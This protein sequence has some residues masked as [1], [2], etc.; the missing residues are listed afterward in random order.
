MRKPPILE[1]DPGRASVTRPSRR[2]WPGK[3]PDRCVVTFFA[4]VIRKLRP[5]ARLVGMMYS[6]IGKHPFYSIRHRGRSVGVLHPGVGAAFGAA[7]LESAISRGCRKFIACGCSG[8][9]DPELGRGEIVVPV[10]AV[11]DEG[12]SYHYLRPSREVAASPRA[13]RAIERTLK[14]HGVPYRRGKTWTTDGFYRETAGK[15]RRRRREGCLVVEMEAAA[16]FAV[17]KF[18][19]ATFGQF[20]YRFDDVSGKKWQTGEW[21]AEYR[22][23]ERMFWL[24]AEAALSL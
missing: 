13:V 14:R 18:R 17:A 7:M 20:L 6:E 8:A 3:V 10:S 19:N 24:A 2:R 21:P 11:R 12:A 15:V 22:L 4:E 16:F 9:L 5:R 1:F 23:R